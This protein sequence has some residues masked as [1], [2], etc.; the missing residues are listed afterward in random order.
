M[1]EGEGEKKHCPMGTSQAQADSLTTAHRL[2]MPTRENYLFIL[3][4]HACSFPVERKRHATGFCASAFSS[5]A[6]IFHN[7]FNHREEIQK[8]SFSRAHP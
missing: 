7:I 6:K 2:H 5:A 4:V 8:T 3:T 1:Q